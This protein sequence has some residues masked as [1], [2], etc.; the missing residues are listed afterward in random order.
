MKVS[1]EEDFRPRRSVFR[2]GTATDRLDELGKSLSQICK[3]E[4]LIHVP[5]GQSGGSRDAVECLQELPLLSVA[6]ICVW[7]VL[8]KMNSSLRAGVWSYWCP[9]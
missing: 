9:K 4:V 6:G 7:V 5:H 1:G 8:H 3:M 2:P